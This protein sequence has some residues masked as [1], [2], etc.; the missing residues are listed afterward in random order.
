MQFSSKPSL[1][2]KCFLLPVNKIL[3]ILK[4]LLWSKYRLKIRYEN[5]RRQIIFFFFSLLLL[6]FSWILKLNK[7]FINYSYKSAQR[8]SLKAEK[9]KLWFFGMKRHRLLWKLF[10]LA[11]N[12]CGIN[13]NSYRTAFFSF[14]VR[15]G[16]RSI[17]SHPSW[18]F[19]MLDSWNVYDNV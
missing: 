5:R 16:T 15:Q 7:R 9:I 1:Y 6:F 13:F 4:L 14:L 8:L 3:N 11:F 10:N 17:H 12:H 19:V 18:W 2:V